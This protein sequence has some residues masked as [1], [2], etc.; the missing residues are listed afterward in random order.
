[1]GLRVA[2]VSWL[3]WC[4]AKCRD[5]IVTFLLWLTAL[6]LSTVLLK[7]GF[8][9]TCL[10]LQAHA[11]VEKYGISYCFF[12]STLLAFA[13]VRV[14]THMHHLQWMTLEVAKSIWFF[15]SQ[16]IQSSLRPTIRETSLESSNTFTEKNWEKLKAR[17]WP[18]KWLEVKKEYRLPDS[19]FFCIMLLARVTRVAAD[20][21]STFYLSTINSFFTGHW[22]AFA[23]LCIS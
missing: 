4:V 9:L 15:Q 3:K 16:I 2:V 12:S 14:G 17:T 23:K 21:V 1:M 5:R 22:T 10:S 20:F 18:G 19:L 6:L 11:V 13:D 8:P 7:G